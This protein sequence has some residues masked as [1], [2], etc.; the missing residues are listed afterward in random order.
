MEEITLVLRVDKER[1]GDQTFIV[2]ARFLPFT[3]D[4]SSKT[5]DQHISVDVEVTIVVE[6]DVG[7]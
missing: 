6:N 3:E 7:R 4:Q 2:M 5:K 1:I